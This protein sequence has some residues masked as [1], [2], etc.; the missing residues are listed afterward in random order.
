MLARQKKRIHRSVKPLEAGRRR[1]AY[2]DIFIACLSGRCILF[3]SLSNKSLRLKS[4][5]LFIDNLS[6][7][8]NHNHNHNQKNLLPQTIAQNQAYIILCIVI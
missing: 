3:K 6:Y 5:D 4:R 1:R 7:S 8:L 2:R